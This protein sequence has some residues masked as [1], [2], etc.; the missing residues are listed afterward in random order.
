MERATSLEGREEEDRGTRYMCSDV[1]VEEE[2][3]QPYDSSPF[4]SLQAHACHAET[5]QI[6]Y[7][8]ALTMRSIQE[9]ATPLQMRLRRHSSLTVEEH[10]M[11]LE[12]RQLSK[13]LRRAH[14]SQE[15]SKFKE[16]IDYRGSVMVAKQCHKTLVI[17]ENEGCDPGEYD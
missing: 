8:L 1:Y 9:S 5:K 4:S 3:I 7:M 16:N 12:T 13:A 17:M 6:F 10:T 15:T 14:V 11:Q 2:T